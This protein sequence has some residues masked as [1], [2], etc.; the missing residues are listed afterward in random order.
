MTPGGSGKVSD[1]EKED[2]LVLGDSD[3]D[4]LGGSINECARCSSR[5]RPPRNPNS[6]YTKIHTFSRLKLAVVCIF[7]HVF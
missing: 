4:T 5:R 6:Q 2:W 3:S 7:E 1:G